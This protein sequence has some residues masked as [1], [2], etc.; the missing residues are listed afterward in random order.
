LSGVIDSLVVELGFDTDGVS[1]GRKQIQD[2]FKSLR[3]DAEGTG[4]RIED[5]SKKIDEAVRKMRNSLLDLLVVFTG[6]KEIK[7]FVQDLTEADAAVTRLS[8]STEMA[9]GQITEFEGIASISGGTAQ[10]MATTLQNLQSAAQ[11]LAITGQSATLPYLR[12]LHIQ[13]KFNKDGAVDVGDELEQLAAG[14]KRLGGGA[15][16][17]EFLRGAGVSDEGTINLL[18]QGGEA[19]KKYRAAIEAAGHASKQDTD[20]ASARLTAWRTFDAAITTVGR[21]ILTFLTPA[22]NGL[23][24]ALTGLA[25]IVSKSPAL[26]AAV[27]VAVGLLTAAVAAL[28]IQLGASYLAGAFTTLLPLLTRLGTAL[29]LLG[30]GFELV[31]GVGVRSMIVAF[32]K[33]ISVSIAELLTNLGLL[34]AT[35]LPSVGDAFVLLGAIIEANP[36]VFLAT[37]IAALGFGAYELIKH[38]SQ[39][40]AFFKGLWDDIAGYFA[41]GVQKIESIPAVKWAMKKLGLAGGETAPKSTPSARSA[42]QGGQKPSAAGTKAAGGADAAISAV[43]QNEDRGLTGK[44]TSDTGGVTKFGIASKSHPGVDVANLSEADAKAIYKKEYWDAIGGDSLPAN[45]QVQALDAAINQGVGNAKKWIKESGGDVN[46]FVALRR[47]QY[48][49]LAAANPGK[50]G[51][52]LKGWESRLPSATQTAVASASAGIPGASAPASGAGTS[53]LA[54][55]SATNSSSTTHSNSEVHIGNVNIYTKATDA[56]GIANSIKPQLRSAAMVAQSQSGA[57]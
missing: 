6:G 31:A 32:A 19:L 22:I 8:R 56:N 33:L 13:L 54:S 51:K 29:R 45:L 42:T 25:E 47:G 23:L 44:V 16:A 53:V 38:W 28:T 55:N 9:A 10:G 27:T 35:I 43:M 5:T 40:S 37:V 49:R 12:A 39:V 50:Y 41:R 14:A 24:N 11:Q 46:K 48:E 2:I 57:S 34:V 26:M 15:R 7:A 52:Y 1:K 36:L 4:K 20:A 3:E 30:V 17:A 21:N 18:L